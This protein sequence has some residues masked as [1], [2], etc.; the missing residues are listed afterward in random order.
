MQNER[1]AQKRIDL[2]RPCW[3]VIASSLQECEIRDISDRGARI[4]V[5]SPDDIPEVFLLLL[6]ENGKSARKCKVVRRGVV[7]RVSAPRLA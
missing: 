4:G 1:R 7:A 6:S 5:K 3:I 2:R